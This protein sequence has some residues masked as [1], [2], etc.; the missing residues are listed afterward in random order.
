MWVVPDRHLLVADHRLVLSEG[1]LAG[2]D[3]EDRE[4]KR[5]ERM[6]LENRIAMGRRFSTTSTPRHLV[7][8][9]ATRALIATAR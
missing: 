1:P 7:R 9:R 6:E 3:I 5:D 2:R 4:M 8:H